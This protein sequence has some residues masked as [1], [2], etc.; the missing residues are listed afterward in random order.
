M[1]D[2]AVVS[3]DL[4]QTLVDVTSR[5]HKVWQEFLQERYSEQLTDEY[6]ALGSKLLVDHFH[7]LTS[8]SKSFLTLK[9]I[10]EVVF[11]ELFPAIGLDF[12]PRKAALVLAAQH[13]LALPYEDTRGFLDA[14]GDE[15]PICLVTDT[16]DDM[17]PSTLLGLY[18]FDSVFTSERMHSYKNDPECRLFSAVVKHYEVAPEKILH[19]GDSSADVLGA[20]CIGIKTCWLNRNSRSWQH[21]VQPDYIVESL[22]EIVPI[23]GASIPGKLR[24][25]QEALL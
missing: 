6:W 18:K 22:S 23:L 10:F 16:D 12:N 9:S 8:Q 5:R 24:M 21:N 17:L 11:A 4:F 20:Y 3:I 13:R 14:V 15:Y 7:R 25:T 1:S 2:F 19:I